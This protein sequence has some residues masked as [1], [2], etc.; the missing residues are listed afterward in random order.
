MSGQLSWI[1]GFAGIL[2]EKILK[3]SDVSLFVRNVQLSSVSVPFGLI[4]VQDR[5]KVMK[6]GMM[7]GFDSAVWG[8]VAI[9]AFGGLMSSVV[10][11]YANNIVKAFATSIAIILTCITSAMLFA[12]YPS[13]LFGLGTVLAVGAVL[14]YS[15]FSSEKSDQPIPVKLCSDDSSENHGATRT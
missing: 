10:I 15:L 7:V 13:I 3:G 14:L 1:S 4:N 2:L 5:D 6:N 12:L 11:K 9:T 8:V